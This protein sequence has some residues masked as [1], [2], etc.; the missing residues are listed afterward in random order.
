MKEEMR[1]E[2]DKALHEKTIEFEELRLASE[3]T[4]ERLRMKVEDTSEDRDQIKEEQEARATRSTT[5]QHQLRTQVQQYQ[6]NLSATRKQL[7]EAQ[8][9]IQAKT[10]QVKQYKKK[11]DQREEKVTGYYHFCFACLSGLHGVRGRWQVGV[12][13]CS[14][15]CA[16]LFM[17]ILIYSI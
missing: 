3:E 9:E 8:Q 10:A 17:L 5:K 2:C 15:H 4:I 16:E 11:D 7:F 1:L 13:K 6:E 12:L 14:L